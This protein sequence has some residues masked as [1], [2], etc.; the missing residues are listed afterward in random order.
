[1][2]KKAPAVLPRVKNW[3]ERTTPPPDDFSNPVYKKPIKFVIKKRVN[4]TLEG[5][6]D[7]K[8]K[9]D[10]EIDGMY[11]YAAAY[12]FYSSLRCQITGTGSCPKKYI[13]Q[14]E[15]PISITAD[16]SYGTIALLPNLLNSGRN[17]DVKKALEMLGVDIPEKEYYA[18]YILKVHTNEMRLSPEVRSQKLLLANEFKKIIEQMEIQSNALESDELELLK[19]VAVRKEMMRRIFF[20]SRKYFSHYN[21]CKSI[22]EKESTVGTFPRIYE[23]RK[24][25]LFWNEGVGSI[26][27]TV[28]S[29]LSKIDKEE[30]S[31]L[32]VQYNQ[33]ITDISYEN[34]NYTF[35]I[36]LD[37]FDY[38]RISD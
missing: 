19:F 24:I 10:T 6:E 5:Q 17:A 1:M 36:T 21:S 30:E 11:K 16:T 4:R 35:E 22:F 20:D 8:H 29:Y 38:T 23:Y 27:N 34:K 18:K 31:D 2:S 13:K 15:N 25:R 28:K 12:S 32:L 26:S 14:I 33:I 9:I 37:G 3:D 7:I